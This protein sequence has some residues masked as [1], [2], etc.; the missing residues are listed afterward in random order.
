MTSL[1]RKK[2][3]KNWMRFH[4]QLIAVGLLGLSTQSFQ[5]AAAQVPEEN[6][7]EMAEALGPPFIVFRD[8][9]LD[10]LKVS[11]DQRD[12]LMQL[13]MKQIMETGPFLESLK[14]APAPERE[15]KLNDHRKVAL[16]KLVKDEKDVLQPDQLKRLRQLTLQ[17]EGGFALGHDEVRKELKIT[18]EQMMKFSAIVQ[19]L[20]K[21]V[22][23]LIKEAQSGG[24][25]EELRPKVEQA[26]RD[27]AKQL[28]AVL[29]EAQKKQ[30]KEMLGPPFEL[31]D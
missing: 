21:S 24:K 30:W 31:E 4:V 16:E 15:E 26:R 19:D 8:K 25:P 29:T 27:H 17:Q 23:R 14:D 6:R 11:D 5:E 20:Q 28:E 12:K 22:E 9:V 1:K 18:P 3:M 10:E 7:R 2:A 13:A